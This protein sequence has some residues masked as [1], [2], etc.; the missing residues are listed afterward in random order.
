[1]TEPT[2]DPEVRQRRR[3]SAE[4][5]EGLGALERLDRWMGAHPWHPRLAPFAVYVVLLWGVGAVEGWWP[6]LNPLLYGGLCAVV[7]WMLWRYRRLTPE[8]N[9]RFHWVAIPA[10]LLGAVWIPLGIGMEWVSP[11]WFGHETTPYFEQM[12]APVAWTAMGVKLLGM[13]IVVPL[14]EELFFRS[15]VL[16][17][18]YRWRTFGVAMFQLL[19]DLPLIGPPLMETK[20]SRRLD[21]YR[22][23]VAAGFKAT[24]LGALS[25]ANIVISI[26]LWCV[27]SHAV[28][29][30]PGTVACGLLYAGVVWYTNRGGRSFG[31]GPVVWAHGLTNA[32]LWGYTLSTGDWRFL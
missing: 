27:L 26:V 3:R 15:A 1:M 14:F 5:G 28:R 24:S 7:A 31:L 22:E 18:F 4:A 8:L 6:A 9:V 10:G 20:L 16:R 23:P 17:S 12:A 11:G 19:E 21:R 13:V 32:V 2:T 25:V 30:W 29:D